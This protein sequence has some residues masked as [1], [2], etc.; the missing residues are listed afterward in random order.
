MMLDS[1][2]EG[3]IEGSRP[4]FMCSRAR[5]HAQVE[6]EEVEVRKHRSQLRITCWLTPLDH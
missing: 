5:G 1:G 3:W 6:G 2:F 4:R